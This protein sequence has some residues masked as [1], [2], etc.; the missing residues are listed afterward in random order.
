M[1]FLFLKVFLVV[2]FYKNWSKSYNV[3]KMSILIFIKKWYYLLVIF[4]FIL[5]LG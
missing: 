5:I 4:C 2:I 1:S 3:L